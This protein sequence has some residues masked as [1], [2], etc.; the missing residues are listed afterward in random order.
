M[1]GYVTDPAGR[2]G[3]LLA[4]DLPEPTPAPDESV[5]EVRAFAINAGEARLIQMRPDRWR[6]GQDVAGVVVRAAADGGGPPVG[7]RVAARLDWEGWAE[8]VPV[9]TSRA[10]RFDDRVS[11]EQAATLPV[12]GLTALRA[13]WQGGAV[14][15]RRVLVTGATGGVGQFAVQLAALAGARVTAWVSGADREEEAR[16]LGAHSVITSLADGDGPFHLVLDGVGG[17][18][19]TEALHRTAPDGTVVLY[20]GPGGAAEIRL[21]DF[22]RS[23]HNG[24]IVGFISDAPED[25]IGADLTVLTDLVAEGRLRPRIGLAADWRETPAAFEALAERKVRGKAVLTIG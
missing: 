21:G 24:R 12:A 8:R 19:L 14:F 20:G 22:Y 6:P 16:E 1:R 4:D 15:G 25:A 10:A 23:A 7:A 17:P 5:V 2:A 3:L 11:F 13:L 18:G 9:P